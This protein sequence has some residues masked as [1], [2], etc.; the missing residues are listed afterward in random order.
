MQQEGML[1]EWAIKLCITYA[2]FLLICVY[3]LA[4]T[5]KRSLGF[6][7]IFKLLN[8]FIISRVICLYVFQRFE[9][10]LVVFEGLLLFHLFEP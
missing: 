2:P 10:L 5:R 1:Y 8:Y 3:S 6:L 4:H 7:R 9:V